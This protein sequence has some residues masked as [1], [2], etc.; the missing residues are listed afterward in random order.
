M[1]S[2][3]KLTSLFV[4]VAA[5]NT[6]ALD[7]TKATSDLDR[8]ICADRDLKAADA[9]MS[10][11]YFKLL[12]SIDDDEIRASLVTSQRRWIKARED[13]LG[14]LMHEHEGRD[15]YPLDKSERRAILL[16]VMRERAKRLSASANG[17]SSFVAIA[18]RQRQLASAYSGGP[19]AGYRGSCSFIP[20][21]ND[22]A[23]WSYACFGS[24]TYQQ[25]DRVCSEDIDFAS[26]TA[27]ITR[28]QYIVRNDRWRSMGSC[29]AG[30]SCPDD[31]SAT[32]H[33]PRRDEKPQ[34]FSS[35]PRE[36]KNLPRIDPDVPY[37]DDD[38]RG[39][40]RACLTDPSFSMDKPVAKH[41]ID[42]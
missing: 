33:S 8:A 37:E 35:I 11:A 34:A 32:D 39:W 18:L 2:L 4:L 21:R 30:V 26:Y 15:E 5:T 36:S 41:S 13:D 23:H 38:D 25:G 1:N 16:E 6:W 29:E 3:M 28:T 42:E 22:G 10:A 31:D 9:A 7:C 24:R 19:L 12:R 14:S 27:V 17:Q 40:M 20:S